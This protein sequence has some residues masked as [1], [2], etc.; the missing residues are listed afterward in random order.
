MKYLIVFNIILLIWIQ[1]RIE[2]LSKIQ[3]S[4]KWMTMDKKTMARRFRNRGHLAKGMRR[5]VN[6]FHL[7]PA[8]SHQAP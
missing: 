2:K 4:Y 7:E 3:V 8:C 1:S 6:S 5:V